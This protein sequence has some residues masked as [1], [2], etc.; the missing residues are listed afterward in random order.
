MSNITIPVT[1]E[2]EPFEDDLRFF[3]ETMVRKLH[4]NRHKGFCEGM[5]MNDLISGLE[6]ELQ[7]LKVARER[8]SQFAVV[9]EA[10]DVAN[11]AFLVAVKAMQM[12]KAEFKENQNGSS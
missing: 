7:E 12:T 10:S 6:V 1:P 11:F 9:L 5:S 2:L 3:V 8:E 4:C